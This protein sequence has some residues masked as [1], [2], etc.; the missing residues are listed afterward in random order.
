MEDFAY[1]FLDGT[2]AGIVIR[3]RAIAKRIY[4]SVVINQTGFF[5]D[6]VGVPES[7]QAIAVAAASSG[8]N[9]QPGGLAEF[10]GLVEG[11]ILDIIIQLLPTLLPVL[12]GLCPK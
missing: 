1:L 6:G 7:R 4:D 5:G 11:P 12:L 2:D 3:K 10:S 8:R 9:A